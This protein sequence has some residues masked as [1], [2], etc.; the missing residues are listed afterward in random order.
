MDEIIFCGVDM[1]A[2][3]EEI[4]TRLANKL[5]HDMNDNEFRA[6]KLGVMNTISVLRGIVDDDLV[7]FVHIP[8]LD[9]E[10]EFTFDELEK[11]W[12]HNMY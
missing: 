2:K 10:K 9:Y 5:V 1:P 8:D 4:S 6:Y 3:V 12:M 11:F 7:M